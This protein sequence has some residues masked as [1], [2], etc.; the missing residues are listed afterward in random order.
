MTSKIKTTAGIIAA[1][2]LLMGTAFSLSLTVSSDVGGLNQ[3]INA[4]KDDS[5]FSRVVLSENA[6]S[7]E[8]V[9]SS[10]SLKDRHWIIDDF[11][12]K[13]EVGVDI[14][15]ADW[16]RYSYTLDNGPDF[17]SAEE[18]I[19]ASRCKKHQSICKDE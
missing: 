16:Y 13:A 3:K 1:A 9:S 7:N 8:I 14:S 6:L 18:T 11:G 5:F 12:D 10:G 15:K 19:N 4:D 2:F 17:A